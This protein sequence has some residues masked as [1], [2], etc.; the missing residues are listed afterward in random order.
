PPGTRNRVGRTSDTSRGGRQSSRVDDR[1]LEWYRAPRPGSVARAWAD[2]SP[3]AC[4]N[5]SEGTPGTPKRGASK[6]GDRYPAGPN[7]KVGIESGGGTV[8]AAGGD[9]VQAEITRRRM[10]AAV[11]EMASIILRTGHTVFVKETSD[12]GAALVSP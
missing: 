10:Q 11:E 12:F 8:T 5:R 9:T 1:R 7:P 2:G 3:G 4:P 6:T